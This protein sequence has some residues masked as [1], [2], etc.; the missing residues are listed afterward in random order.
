MFKMY[1]RMFHLYVLTNSM[2]EFV[3]SV[4][5]F[6][7]RSQ[8]RIQSVYMIIVVRQLSEDA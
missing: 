4:E 5:K 8:Y 1:M 2:K 6:S 3:H 7:S